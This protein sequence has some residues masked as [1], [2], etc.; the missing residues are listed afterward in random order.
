MKPRRVPDLKDAQA[1]RILGTA[2]PETIRLEGMQLHEP[3]R[4]WTWR[5]IV[6]E[7]HAVLP[8]EGGVVVSKLYYRATVEFGLIPK[9]HA[10]PSRRVS[11][12][13]RLR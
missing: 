7:Q 6:I 1:G 4:G 13:R 9:A 2:T 12:T 8:F 3:P 11:S 5:G 10:K